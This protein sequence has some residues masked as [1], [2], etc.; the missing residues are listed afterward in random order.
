MTTHGTDCHFYP[1]R[2]TSFVLHHVATSSASDMPGIFGSYK[3]DSLNSLCIEISYDIF[4]M[5]AERAF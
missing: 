3:N 2:P 5:A 1:G 4:I